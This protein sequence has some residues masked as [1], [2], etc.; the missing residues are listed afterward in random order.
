MEKIRAT[1]FVVV[2]TFTCEVCSEEIPCEGYEKRRAPLGE[3][4]DTE[5]VNQLCAYCARESLKW[6]N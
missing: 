3:R 2:Q 5:Y 6:E 4:S 1:R